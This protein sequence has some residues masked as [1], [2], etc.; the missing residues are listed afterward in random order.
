MAFVTFVSYSLGIDDELFALVPKK[1]TWMTEASF[2]ILLSTV[3]Y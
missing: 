3:R 1:N 2:N